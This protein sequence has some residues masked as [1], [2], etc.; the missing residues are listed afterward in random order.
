MIDNDGFMI[1]IRKE[2]DMMAS[3]IGNLRDYKFYC[4]NGE[5]KL[6]QVISDRAVDEKIDF[7]DMNTTGAI[8]SH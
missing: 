7:Y 5:P 4:F 3:K 2:D 1:L 6:C 8:K